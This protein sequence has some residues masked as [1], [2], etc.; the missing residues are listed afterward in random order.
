MIFSF[1]LIRGAM[2]VS[3]AEATLARRAEILEAAL[4]C[5][6]D[7]GYEKTTIADIKTRARASTGSIYHHFSS[8][9]QLFAE[10]Y[11]EVIR[12]AQDTSIQALK[13]AKS[14]AEGVR[15]LVSSYLRWVD[16]EPEKAAFLLTMRRAEF[17]DDVE[18][19]LE[20]LNHELRK[21]L[22]EW[23]DRH[24]RRG[25]L[26]LAKAD[27]LMALLVGPSEDFARRW[28]R[29][30]TSTS[31]REAADLLGEAAWNAL[32]ALARKSKP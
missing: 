11:L 30:R 1:A 8:K 2:A 12:E 19:E 7:L 26:P 4:Q 9:E 29:G 5:F 3:R 15:S 28:L 23:T 31:L 16:R 21:T 32:R 10:L 13:R 27:V 18:A 25:E 24:V 20:A 22:T 14:A 17:M 6:H